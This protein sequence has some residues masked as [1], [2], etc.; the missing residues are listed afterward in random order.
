M[1]IFHSLFTGDAED[2]SEKEMLSNRLDLKAGHHGSK[3][4]STDAFLNAV[5]PKYA[6]ISVGKDDD[7]GHPNKETLQKF[8]RRGIEVYRTDESGTIVADSDGN[9]ITFS[10]I[11]STS[12][13]SQTVASS[14]NNSDSNI[15]SS[16]S[17][18]SS[19]NSTSTSQN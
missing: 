10:A 1:E 12:N 4:S 5:N 9:K 11:P 19:N 16:N 18:I 3:S 17:S 14:K 2:V 8:S 6:V 7:Y 13:V 15:L